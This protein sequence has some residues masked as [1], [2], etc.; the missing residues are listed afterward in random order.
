MAERL[1]MAEAEFR[2]SN[3]VKY[4]RKIAREHGIPFTSLQTRTGPKDST[5]CQSKN[6]HDEK[7][8]RLLPE[9]E[10]ALID[11]ILQMQ[12]WGWPPRCLQLRLMAIELLCLK[13]DTAPLGVNW[14]QKFLRRHP[15]LATRF[16]QSLDKE[17]AMMH[18]T[19]KIEAWFELFARVMI[20]YDIQLED[21][22]N[23]DEKGFAMG[24]LGSLQVICSKHERAQKALITQCGNREWVSLLETVSATGKILK[25][26]IIL[27][28]KV[29]LK[30]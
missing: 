11:W 27:K 12:A 3:N 18:D 29:V 6:E 30:A 9:A 15:N 13:G 20:E 14:N 23:M 2:S 7:R 21:L 22:Y 10:D 8:Q 16:T 17:R 4:K 25:P 24:I 1:H 19:E 28:G 26:W 5:G